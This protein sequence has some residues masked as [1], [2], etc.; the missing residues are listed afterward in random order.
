MAE[1]LPQREFDAP[2]ILIGVIPPVSP[3]AL[4]S[5][6]LRVPPVAI[7]VEELIRPTLVEDR[8]RTDVVPDK[9]PVG[10]D[11]EAGGRFI[12]NVVPESGPVPRVRLVSDLCRV[13]LS[14]VVEIRCPGSTDPS[15]LSDVPCGGQLA[16]HAKGVAD[17]S[18]VGDRV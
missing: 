5:L 1:I 12:L 16:E 17:R 15:I 6:L 14:V 8:Q 11:L 18:S 2:D 9:V 4:G 3:T 13:D 7:A 10:P